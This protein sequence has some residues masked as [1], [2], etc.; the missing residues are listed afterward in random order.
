MDE[1]QFP[2]VIDKLDKILKLLAIE[3]VKGLAREQDKIELLD[4]LDFKSGEID[5][6][7]G[8][9]SGYSSVVLSQLKKKKQPKIPTN[10][11]TG[12]STTPATPEVTT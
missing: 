2:V 4:S 8:K 5:R 9:S 10:Q 11:T 12:T 3:T 7:L 6:L 1:K